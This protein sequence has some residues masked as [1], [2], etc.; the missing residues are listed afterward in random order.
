[1]SFASNNNAVLKYRLQHKL[2]TQSEC[3]ANV[4]RLMAVWK[5]RKLSILTWWIEIILQPN[6][7]VVVG[8]VKRLASTVSCQSVTVSISS[9]NDHVIKYVWNYQDAT[10]I[11][12]IPGTLTNTFGPLPLK[13]SCFK[14]SL[15]SQGS[16]LWSG[17]QKLLVYNIIMLQ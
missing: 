2:L 5:V 17:G 10:F 14:T 16:I 3:N 9:R 4:Q 8:K 11:V 12:C 1:M 6:Q 15:K 13:C 7:L